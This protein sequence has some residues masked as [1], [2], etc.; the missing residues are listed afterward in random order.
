MFNSFLNYDIETDTTLKLALEENTESSLNDK[1]LT[2]IQFFLVDFKTLPR[3]EFNFSEVE[4][5]VKHK[6]IV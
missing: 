4:S 1:Y 6:K 2:L 5:K 3:K